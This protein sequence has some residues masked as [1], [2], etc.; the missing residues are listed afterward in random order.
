MKR[1]RDHANSATL[2]G[3]LTPFRQDHQFAYKRSVFGKL[4]SEY[5]FQDECPKDLHESTIFTDRMMRLK[6]TNPFDSRHTYS[7][8]HCRPFLNLLTIL[9]YQKL[10]I[11]Q[12]HYLLS[13]TEDIGSD[14]KLMKEILNV[15]SKYPEY[16]DDVIDR[17]MKDFK[18]TTKE[19]KK[20]V[21]RS[22][23]PLLDWAKQVGLVSVQKDGWCLITEKGL[24]VQNFYSSFFP[25]WLDQLDFAPASQAALLLI[26]MYAH[27]QGA[28]VNPGKLPAEDRETL[29]SLNLKFGLW[30]QSLTRLKMPVDFD[31][32]YDIHLEWRESVLSYVEKLKKE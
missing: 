28:R 31:L 16:E 27:I 9:R 2:L 7:K 17:F 29:K 12:V 20:E 3:L 6:L 21:S 5:K 4:L 25:I 8:F 32:N 24:P 1:A 30:N 22:T 14:L 15:F 26:Y 18:I 19:R 11:S 10:H 13:I 23:K